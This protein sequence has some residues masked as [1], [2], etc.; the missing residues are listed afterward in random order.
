[1]VRGDQ[2]V[3]E[4]DEQCLLG[5][6]IWRLIRATGSDLVEANVLRLPVRQWELALLEPSDD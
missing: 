6:I 4:P 5:G 3:G 1:M 2:R